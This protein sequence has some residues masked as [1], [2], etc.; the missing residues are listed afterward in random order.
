MVLLLYFTTLWPT[1]YTQ[2]FGCGQH[3]TQITPQVGL[4]YSFA[5]ISVE[6]LFDLSQTVGP[7]FKLK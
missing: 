2:I 1:V 3:S 4:F 7:V 6:C 5:V